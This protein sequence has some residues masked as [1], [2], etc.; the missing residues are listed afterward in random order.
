MHPGPGSVHAND[1]RAF[2]PVDTSETV[3]LGERFDGKET[4]ARARRGRE[5][6]YRF[7]GTRVEAIAR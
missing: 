7:T 2:S 1:R 6:D 5:F 4:H 3:E